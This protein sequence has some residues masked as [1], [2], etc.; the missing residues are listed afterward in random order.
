MHI[1]FES[2]K[3]LIF[4]SLK[5]FD[6]IKMGKLYRTIQYHLKEPPEGIYNVLQ[7]SL[8]KYYYIELDQQLC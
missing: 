7:A 2:N 6:Y 1:S 4:R 3:F 8:G 5:M